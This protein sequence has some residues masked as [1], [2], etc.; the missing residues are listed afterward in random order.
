VPEGTI[1]ASDVQPFIEDLATRIA[2]PGAIGFRDMV[3][4]S[5]RLHSLNGIW[6]ICERFY[7]RSVPQ[8]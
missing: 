4:A 3:L 2:A 6:T 5:A 1:T 8:A 7:H